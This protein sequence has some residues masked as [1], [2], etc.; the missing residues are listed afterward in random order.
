MKVY[1]CK[2][3][4]TQAFEPKISQCSFK[5]SDFQY[6]HKTVEIIAIQKLKYV[7]RYCSV[8]LNNPILSDN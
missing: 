7:S 4:M 3:E 2:L 6:F 8:R 1:T 5:E